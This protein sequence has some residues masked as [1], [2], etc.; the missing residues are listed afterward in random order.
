MQSPTDEA[1]E[2]AEIAGVVIVRYFVSSRQLRDKDGLIAAGVHVQPMISICMYRLY[3]KVTHKNQLPTI[4]YGGELVVNQLLLRVLGNQFTT[5]HFTYRGFGQ[6]G[7]E[8]K[9]AWNFEFG[10]ILFAER[11]E[12]FYV[13]G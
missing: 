4:K 10:Q 11:L 3:Q 5:Q 9:L 1:G 12:R 8:F 2:C 6:F 13:D 7:A